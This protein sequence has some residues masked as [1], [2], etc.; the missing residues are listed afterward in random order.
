MRFPVYGV[1]ARSLK[2][3]LAGIGVGG[4]L[5]TSA[6]VTE[7]TALSGFNL[8][9]RAGDR[10]GLVGHNGAGKTTLLRALA[11]AYEPDEGQIEVQGRIAA[12]LDIG[13]GLDPAA[14]GRD[15]ILL[16]A[17]I[18][19]M[20]SKDI[21]RVIDEI[22][23]FTGLG[24]FLSLPVKSYSTGMQARLAFAAAT[25]VEAD[26][27]LMDEWVSVGDADFKKL[28]QKRLEEMTGRAGILVLASHDHQLLSLYCNKVLRLHHGVASPVVDIS[29]LADLLAA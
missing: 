27:L 19:G 20:T 5:A 22:E 18:A 24:Q 2:K 1:D 3:R 26:V 9:L 14:T 12:L 6:G 28:A 11:G 10:L 13:L 17:R 8:E 21:K 15:N 7:V 23:D 25:S 29:Q 16:R 4:S